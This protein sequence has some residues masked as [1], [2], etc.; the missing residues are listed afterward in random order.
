MS[1]YQLKDVFKSGQFPEYTY[2]N[3]PDI[4]M[5]TK[6]EDY[7]EFEEGKCLTI[8]GPSKAGKTVA[9]QKML[10]ENY[11]I[12]I[13]GGSFNSIDQFY[14]MISDRLDLYAEITTSN[15]KKHSLST[16]IGIQSLFRFAL[17]ND[18]ENSSS[19]KQTKLNISQVKDKLSEK[20][21]PLVI[22]DF[23]FI[24]ENLQKEISLQIKDLIRLTNVILISIPET[25]FAPL[26]N[27]PDM[28]WRTVDMP[29]KNWSVNEL[30]EIATKGF[31]LLNIEDPDKKISLE[32]A[33]HSYGAPIIM[34][35]LCKRY[36]RQNLR[37]RETSP[38]PLVAIPVPDWNK[39][40]QEIAL[41]NKPAIFE[42]LASGKNTRG[43]KRVLIEFNDSSK[44]DIYISILKTIKN[45]DEIN[46]S[47]KIDK[48][49]LRL[50]QK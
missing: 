17:K 46:I 22:D 45:M 40:F 43:K 8:Y 12:W 14:H 3:R 49:I 4:K 27:I 16:S 11:A 36:T 26:K 21:V 1:I 7:I 19:K 47:Q 24:N 10:P 28:N 9:V 23:H 39:F 44:M 2:Y 25:S 50:I 33:T 13:S 5:E 37:L 38:T 48:K 6:I 20:P 29:I 34:Q 15:T 30:T 35:D 41:S 42:K 18:N 31:R 32:L